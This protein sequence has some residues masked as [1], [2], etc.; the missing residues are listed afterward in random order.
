[1]P[2]DAGN[3]LPLL[4][5]GPCTARQL[6]AYLGVSQPTVSR[7]VSGMGDE[8]V[9]FG[10]ARSIQYT[11]R[12]RAR[13]LPEIPIYRVNAQGE[14]QRLGVMIPVRPEGFVMQQADGASH[15]CAGLPWWLFDMRPQGFLGRAYALRHGARLGLPERLADWNDTHALRALLAHGHDVVGNLLLGDTA[16][17]HFLETSA[18]SPI[19]VNDKAAAYAALARH[20]AQ[21]DTPGSSAGGE[22]PKFTAFAQTRSGPCH[23]IVKFTEYEESPVSERW[24]DLLLAEHH[25]LN[26]LADAGIAAARTQVIDHDGQRFLEAE[27]FDRVGPLGRRALISLAALDAEFVGAG[28][29]GWPAIVNQLGADRHIRAEAARAAA[30]LWA[31]GTLIGNTDLHNGN[32]SFV[33]DQGRP[34]ELAPAYDMTPMGLAPRSGGGLP[35]TLPAAT[36]HASVDNKTW[37]VAAQLAADF[38]AR[39]DAETRLS[40]RFAPC[41]AAL[42]NHLEIASA[43]IERLG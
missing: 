13:G 42:K 8:I 19:R 41:V 39:I 43:K 7:L 16:R 37:R 29:G 17:A 22:Q 35:D 3:I 31:F 32:L 26:T 36:I 15:H 23:V 11:L 34:Y 5:N 25:A 6:S 14:I 20:A 40:R 10:A 12:D 30:L 1:M 18:P 33:T 27:R 38:L 28:S 2:P 21:G 24:R 9:R 4:N